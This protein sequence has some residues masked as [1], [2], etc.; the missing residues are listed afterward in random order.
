MKIH[1]V[2][3]TRVKMEIIF[4]AHLLTVMKRGKLLWLPN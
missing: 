3:L 4:T 1:T 2:R